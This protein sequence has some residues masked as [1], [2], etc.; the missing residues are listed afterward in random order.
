MK[1]NVEKVR[2]FNNAVADAISAKLTDDDIMQMAESSSNL[3]I[4]M[5]VAKVVEPLKDDERV[6]ALYNDPKDNDMQE[7]LA[8]AVTMA[9][10]L[11]M[12][13]AED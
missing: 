8:G 6:K 1:F 7:L 3:T 9:I 10:G 4:M 2:Q 5:K 12:V 11:L 13:T